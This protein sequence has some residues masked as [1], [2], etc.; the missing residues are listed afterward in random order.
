MAGYL[1]YSLYVLLAGLGVKLSL[2]EHVVYCSVL[3][4]A[5]LFYAGLVFDR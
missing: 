2:S 1:E 3:L 4:L 5:L